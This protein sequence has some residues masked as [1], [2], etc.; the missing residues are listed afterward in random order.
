MR[1]YAAEAAAVLKA[2]ANE[3]RLIILCS[4]VSCPLSVGQLNERVALSQSALSQH[5]G[6]LREAGL[7]STTRVSQ[8]IIYS[9]PPGIASRII[10]LLHEEF[11]TD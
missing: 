5:L 7:V 2:L 4:L 3:Q 8:S 9:L 11:C 1:P 6:V 10:G